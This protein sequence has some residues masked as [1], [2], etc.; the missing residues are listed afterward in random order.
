[1]MRHLLILGLFVGTAGCTSIEPLRPDMESR[2]LPSRLD[3]I[4]YINGLRKAYLQINPGSSVDAKGGPSDCYTGKDLPVFRPKFVQG[5]RIVDERSESVESPACLLFKPSKQPGDLKS[6]L[7][8]YLDNGYGL[9]DL[10][11]S[12]FM[13]I[14]AETRQARQIQKSTFNAVNVMMSTVLNALSAGANAMNVATGGFGLIDSTYKNID[15]AFVITP[16]KDTL[17]R[18][19]QV[20][21]ASF[22]KEADGTP[23]VS[24]ADA[25]ARLERYSS[26][27]TYDAMKGMVNT[28]VLLATQSLVEEQKTDTST[29]TQKPAPN[30]P[31]RTPVSKEVSKPKP[32]T[33]AMIPPAF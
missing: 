12:R 7:T 10:Y 15:D 33:N 22:R 18:L 32:T 28:S 14:A 26:I 3:E 27:C 31:K 8:D 5:Y 4:A 29:T 24:Y 23:P 30:P 13:I 17:V 1:M 20:A 16:E 21:Q 6:A 9:A 25:R 11:C 2:P 19:V